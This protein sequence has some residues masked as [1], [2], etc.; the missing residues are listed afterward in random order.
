MDL[1]NIKS[2]ILNELSNKSDI[3]SLKLQNHIYGCFLIMEDIAQKKFDLFYNNVISTKTFTFDLDKQFSE[4]GLR[5]G[6][7]MDT[8]LLLDKCSK[9]YK[10]IWLKYFNDID[11]SNSIDDVD[12]IEDSLIEV[13]KNAVNPNIAFFIAALENGNLS[14]DWVDKFI[15]LLAAPTEVQEEEQ[16]EVTVISKAHTE[17]PVK[18]R[19]S[20]TRRNHS[21]AQPLVKKSL[22][23]TRRHH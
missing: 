16:V 5:Y 6:F 21:K 9:D 10:D 4:I 7:V 15:K 8:K 20:T 19:L 12:K 14:H 3:E 17:K 13:V 11:I 22:S 2:I 23:K 1:T 18:R